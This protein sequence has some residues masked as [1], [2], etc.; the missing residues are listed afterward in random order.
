[1]LWGNLPGLERVTPTRIILQ[2]PQYAAELGV[3]R[4]VLV[5]ALRD[6]QDLM[7]ISGLE[8]RH[9]HCVLTINPPPCWEN[10]EEFS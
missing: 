10:L 6:L 9:G 5:R 3:K 2:T 7:V 8:V 4:E 1:M